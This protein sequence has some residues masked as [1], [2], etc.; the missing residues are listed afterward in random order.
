M[1]AMN[2]RVSAFIFLLAIVGA[3]CS[4]SIRAEETKHKI[5]SILFDGVPK[6]GT[7]KVQKAKKAKTKK[8]EKAA[9]PAAAAP[10]P[11][12]ERP[13]PEIEK[14]KTWEEVLKVLPK[15]I[16]GGPDWVKAVKDGIIAPRAH[17]PADP[18]QAAP[19]TLDNLVLASASDTEPT[20]DLNVE[21]IP[22][23]APLYKVV[24]PHSSH[25]LWLNCS[26]CHPGIVSERGS[27]MQKILAGEYCGR[28]HGTVAFAPLTSC[29]RCHVNLAPAAK[30]TMEADLVEGARSQAP[31]SPEIVERGK[32]VYLQAC[33][34]CHNENGN[35]DGPLAE[36]LNPKPKN[37]TLGL[38]KFRST[39]SASLP[40]DFD[41]F[42]T[43]TLG[44]QGTA[45]PGYSFL[46]SQDRFAVAQFL[47]TFSGRFEKQ[48]P[49]EPIA[50]PEPPPSTPAMMEAGQTLYKIQ[51][52]ACHGPAGHGDGPAAKAMR[53]DRGPLPPFDFTRGRPKSGSALK[54]YYRA[55]M[56]GLQGTPMPDFGRMLKPEQ[57]WGLVYY[58]YSLGDEN[59]SLPPA[60]KDH[61]LYTRK[62]PAKESPA[63]AQSAAPPPP[64][65]SVQPGADA[66]PE[67][68]PPATFPHWFHRIR[69]RCSV[70]HPGITP[71]LKVGA[72]PIT[73]DALR[74]GRFCGRC[75]P[76]NPDPKALVAW[77][78]SFESCGRCHVDR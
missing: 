48:K 23:K 15:D 72:N 17:L 59:R 21:I 16:V 19:Y 71:I 10:D 36:A 25:T 63:N 67:D 78:L 38:F 76:S 2:P 34:I 57:A 3:V 35:G 20:L 26:S 45:M 55:I 70:C 32:A 42:R 13:R 64:S 43:I 73:M 65:A 6:P 60:V 24:F 52:V 11:G 8:G 31:S 7:E 30:E 27:G 54:D 74:A 62:A 69:F 68:V 33:A 1:L 58:L 77:T 4:L 22:P 18:K 56:T 50:I 61:F 47:K 53:D 12:V 75:H 49:A 29:A 51:C 14:L 37:F 44:I 28:C 66:P 46:P 5:L 40:T 41:L 9:A 39:S